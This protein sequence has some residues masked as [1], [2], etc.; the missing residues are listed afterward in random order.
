MV[1]RASGRP[2]YL[3]V[4]DALRERIQSG[5]YPPG[6]QLPS[7]RELLREFEV[8]TRTTR[9]A[10][11]HLRAEGHVV[12][13]QGRGVFV[14]EQKVTRR[15]TS[16]MLTP[17]TTRGWYT[18]VARQGLQ[19]AT[20]TSVS[21]VPCPADVAEWLGIEPGT[22]VWVRDRV[23]RV[24]GQ[25]AELLGTSY[26]PMWV[27]EMVPKLKDPNASGMIT[28]LEDAGYA[29]LHW[30]DVITCRMPSERE[31]ELLDLP[32]GTPVMV[33]NGPTY[34]RDDRPL[35]HVVMV[36]ASDRLELAYQYGEA[37]TDE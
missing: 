27:V 9:A 16:D 8:S 4:A 23:M 21:Q 12:S 15:L 33:V 7:E 28:W 34:D 37:L 26:F 36:V 22:S 6:A 32:P 17:G 24:E 31:R 19:P 35:T 13:Y 3:Q 2:A 25:P 18:A 5:Q 1:S 30:L 29:P 10:I 11:D 20:K 14:R